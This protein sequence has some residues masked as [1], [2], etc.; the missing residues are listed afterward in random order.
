MDPARDEV[1]VG[2]GIYLRP[3]DGRPG[4]G[5]RV[6]AAGLIDDPGAELQPRPVVPDLGADLVR[7]P[8][9]KSICGGPVGATLMFAALAHHRWFHLRTRRKWS[10]DVS[11]ARTLVAALTAGAGFDMPADGAV[12]QMVD[13]RVVDVLAGLGWKRLV[14]PAMPP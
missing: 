2:S 10:T 11:G 6:R 5:E 14:T 12:A 1:V 8:E 4:I 13:A 3:C 9:A 7:S